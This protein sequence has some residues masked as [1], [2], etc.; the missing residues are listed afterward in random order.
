MKEANIVPLWYLG[1]EVLLGPGP[2]SENVPAYM[3]VF[4]RKMLP[5]S[6]LL[7]VKVLTD[8]PTRVLEITDIKH[9]VRTLTLTP[10]EE[11]KPVKL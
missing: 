10:K 11:E 2:C 7:A 5:G 1:S 6:G 8:G 3:S 4:R 9:Q